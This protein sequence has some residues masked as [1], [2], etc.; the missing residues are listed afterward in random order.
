MRMV[1]VDKNIITKLRESGISDEMK[2]IESS[3]WI[4]YETIDNEIIGPIWY[5]RNI[6]FFWCL[7]CLA[8]WCNWFKKT[9]SSYVDEN[10]LFWLCLVYG[11]SWFINNL[12]FAV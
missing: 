4:I 10:F 2:S 6:L 12:C 5:R 7:Y 3:D 1:N 11:N 9:P 8:Y